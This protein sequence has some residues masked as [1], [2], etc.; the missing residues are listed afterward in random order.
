MLYRHVRTKLTL[1][2]KDHLVRRTRNEEPL[3]NAGVNRRRLQ[4]LSL[5]D[6]QLTRVLNLFRTMGDRRV[7]KRN[8]TRLSLSRNQSLPRLSTLL[9]DIHRILPVLTLATER[10]LVFG[11][12]VRDLVDAE[13]F[14]GRADQTRQVALDVLDVVEFGGQRVVDVDDDDLPVG[15]AFVEEGH[16][17][18][19]FYLLDLA[20]VSDCFTDFT[21]IERV[22][23]AGG[24]GVGVC[25]VGVF[26]GL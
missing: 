7:L 19:N 15:F 22:V 13:P 17:A 5:G 2:I 26:P 10:K 1:Q 9:D 12:S 3:V 14:V 16:H 6:A 18:E 21:D 25:A 8:L 4:V 20:G 11:L 23:V 24:F